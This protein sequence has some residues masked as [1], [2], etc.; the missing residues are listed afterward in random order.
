MSLQFDRDTKHAIIFSIPLIIF[1]LFMLIIWSGA[2][3]TGVYADVNGRLCQREC[4]TGSGMVLALNSPEFGMVYLLEDGNYILSFTNCKIGDTI[5]VFG[6]LG[7]IQSGD[8]FYT[9]LEITQ[10]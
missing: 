8:K 4:P 1:L 6:R 2:L 10:K 7:E 5:W 9:T 3:S